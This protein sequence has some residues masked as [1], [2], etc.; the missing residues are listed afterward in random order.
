MRRCK[1]LFCVRVAVCRG[2]R[3]GK[4]VAGGPVGAREQEG[5]KA[6][7][8]VIVKG[9][10]QLIMYVS[11]GQAEKTMADALQNPGCLRV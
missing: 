9:F 1:L 11:A 10:R 6:G 7:E 4:G 5:R 3:G 2:L 8:K